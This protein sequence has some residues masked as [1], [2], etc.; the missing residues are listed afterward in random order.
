MHVFGK[1][2]S[3]VGPLVAPQGR[4]PGSGNGPGTKKEGGREGCC[5]GSVLRVAGANCLHRVRCEIAAPPHYLEMR[6][7]TFESEFVQGSISLGVAEQ[8]LEL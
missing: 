3:P 1:P 4:K 8:R 2:R 6:K 5:K 7:Q